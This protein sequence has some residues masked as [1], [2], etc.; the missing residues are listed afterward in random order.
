MTSYYNTPSWGINESYVYNQNGY[1][2]FTSGTQDMFV[3]T[4]RT[5]VF[6]M[7]G[8][9]GNAIA[10]YP[11]FC[12]VSNTAFL[13]IQNYVDDAYLVYPGYGFQLFTATNYS[14][15]N[16]A[17]YSYTYFNSGNQPVV[18]SLYWD[19]SNLTFPNAARGVRSRRYPPGFSTNVYQ[20]NS[21]CSIKIYYKNT[22][23]ITISG[24]S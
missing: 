13:N 7:N 18:F 19:N 4:D 2:N 23:P 15:D 21:T 3:S 11:I 1:D 5:G 16:N 12:S 9:Q 24:I 20:A 10:Y 14:I 6:L 22:T 17:N 8:S